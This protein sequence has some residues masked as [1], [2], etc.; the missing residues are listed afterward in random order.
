MEYLDVNEENNALIALRHENITM[1]TTHLEVD[2]MCILGVVSG[3]IPFP[4]HN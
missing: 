2:P 4:N 3:I 1:D